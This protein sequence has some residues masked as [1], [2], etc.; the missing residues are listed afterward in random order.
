MNGNR[1]FLIGII[2][3]MITSLNGFAQIEK[4]QYEVRTERAD[5]LLGNFIIELFPGIAPLHS[6]YFDSLVSESFY[7]STAIHRIAPGFVI[8]G[9]DPN[10]ING[11]EDTWGFGDSNQ[12]N[13]P[14]EFSGVSHQYGIIGAA[15]DTDINSANSQYYVNLGNNNFLDWNYTAYGR[16]LE[17]MDFVEYIATVPYDSDTERPDEKI[18]VFITRMGETNST[19]EIPTILSPTNDQGGFLEKDTLKWETDDAVMYHLQ[20]SKS[21]TFDSLIYDGQHGF[22][23]Y[24]LED[25]EFPNIDYYWKVSAHN[26]GNESE[27][28]EVHHFSSSIEAP[29]LVYPIWN[30]DS[31]SVTPEFRW[32]PVDGATKYRL[33]I[34]DKV[35]FTEDLIVYDVDTITNIFHTPPPLE[36]DESYYWQVYSMTDE[37]QGPKSEYRRFVTPALTGVTDVELPNRFALNQNYPNPFNPATTISYSIAKSSEVVIKLFNIQGKEIATLINDQQPQGN[38]KI[39]FDASQLSSGVYYY[40]INAGNFTETKKMVFLK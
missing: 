30:D 12:V 38:Y 22:D 34:S 28:S 35:Y 7:D 24:A 39:D 27:F 20:I 3:C 19:P 21:P 10:S 36:P 11:P 16:V 5:T 26:G 4:P 13:I 31:I 29:I 32:L 14:A 9:G 23:F 40:Q 33:Q 1:L 2:I 25:V 6:A 15:R 37:Y 17:G 18:E 8:Q